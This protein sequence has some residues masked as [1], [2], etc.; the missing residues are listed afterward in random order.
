MAFKIFLIAG[1]EVEKAGNPRPPVGQLSSVDGGSRK[2]RRTDSVTSATSDGQS[3]RA[4][5]A[6]LFRRQ[7]KV[8]RRKVRSFDSLVPRNSSHC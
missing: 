4:E 5:V 8:L 3:Q 1:A 2:R 6:Q 7:I